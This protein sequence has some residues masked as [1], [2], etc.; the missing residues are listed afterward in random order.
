M[1][2]LTKATLT[3]I[4]TQMASHSWSEAEIDELVDPRLGMITGFQD[5]LDELEQL[6]KIDLGTTPQAMSVQGA[7]KHE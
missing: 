4:C 7:T 3:G 2:R 6:R 1:Q 5:L